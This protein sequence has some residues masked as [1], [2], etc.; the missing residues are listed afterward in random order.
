MSDFRAAHYLQ[1]P[2]A[3]CRSF[4]GLRWAQYGEAV[5]FLEGPAAGCTFAFAA[6]IAVFLE[7]LQGSGGSLL[8]FGFVLHLLYLIGLGDR[9]ARHGK[10]SVVCV[11][12]IA[13]PFRALGCPLRNAGALCSWLCRGAPHVADPPD[14]SLLHEILTG[15]SWVPQMVLSH[16]LLGVMDHALEPGLE[17]AEFVDLVRRA[18]EALGDG[19]I[20]HWLRHGRGPAG[21]GDERLAPIRPRSLSEALAE[22]ERRPRL[23]GIGRL[24][25]R[26]EAALSLPP[27]RLAWS[28]LQDGGYADVT[29]K[30]A[31][32]QILPM[33]FALEGE[34][35]LRRFAERELLYFHREEPRQPMTEEIILLIDQ[36]VRTWGDVRLVLTGAALAL[37]RQSERRRIAVRL[38]GTSNDGAAVDPTEVNPQALFGLLEASD[39]SA[40]PGRA[41]THLLEF[42]TAAW[43]DIVLL[44]HPRSLVDPDVAAA[45]RLLAEE[46]GTRLFAVTVDS[47]GQLELTELRRGLPVVLAHSRIDLPADR[48]PLVPAR[49]GPDHPARAPWEGTFESIGFPFHCGVLDQPAGNRHSAASEFDFDEAGDRILIVGRHGLLFTCR[50]DG[51]DAET[52]PRPRVDGP[53]ALLP[54]TVLGVA[55]GFVLEGTRQGGCMLAHYDFPTRTCRLHEIGDA[56]TSLSWLYYRD[57]HAIARP[58]RRDRASLAFDLSGRGTL[59]STST[60]ASRAA[61][62]A[63]AG[64]LPY[65]LADVASW[66][67]ASESWADTS[68]QALLLDSKSGTLRF[69]QGSGVERSVKPLC[70]GRPAL[71]RGRIVRSRQGGDT[72]AVMIERAYAPGLY[73]ISVSRST[74]LGTIPTEGKDGE[75][76]FALSRDGLRFAWY[77]GDRPLEVRDVP[78]GGPPVLVTPEENLS[79]HFA[80]LGFSCLLVREF[81]LDGP[82][83]VRSS[84]LIR[85][86]QGRLEVAH[87][88]AVALLERL[89]GT[90]AVSR[91]IPTGDSGLGYDP[92]RFFVQQIQHH[93][94]RILIDRYNHL[95]VLK[96]TGD[97]SCMF[98]VSGDEVAAWLPDGTRLGPRRLIGG[99]PTAGARERIAAALASSIP[100][101]GR[102]S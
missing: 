56:H 54:R 50:I 98:Y 15:G 27:R 83:H 46:G 33:Q 79:I 102:T 70:N 31:P 35:F 2:A 75:G 96:Q 21:T 93:G 10:S 7:G 20:R 30:G 80:T 11:E 73:F 45:A 25:S 12:R 23:A 36:G 64:I 65:P 39:L 76:L 53:V 57:L 42:T 14:L 6:E 37:A 9:A 71:E 99:E 94:R 78:G 13:A 51:T 26:L 28:L 90:V 85:W 34:E 62:R 3:Y 18:A 89:G 60:R 48:A 77:Q 17:S 40:H 59:E 68:C 38:A 69:Q 29:T 52:L 86:D 55:G 16:P 72:L 43:R 95:A 101:G 4:G 5:E 19:E 58:A 81:D 63:N 100:G 74:V 41:L 1:I 8:G 44:T 49:A 61:A 24:T 88:E 22:L 82:R 97:L 92:H 67:S 87:R 47:G 32:E 91:S 66:T 84:C